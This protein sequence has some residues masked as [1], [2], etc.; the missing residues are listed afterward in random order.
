MFG[1]LLVYACVTTFSPGPNNILLL[2]MAG[3]QGVKKC[4]KLMAGI[5]TGFFFVMVCCGLFSAGL[6]K[7]VPE[8]MPYAKYVGAAYIFWLA[9]KTVTRQPMETGNEKQREPSFWMGLVLQLVNVKII[10][11][12]ISAF[13]GFILPY[14]QGTAVLLFYSFVLMAA[15]AAGNMIWAFIGNIC[16]K[17][18]SRY[19]K[20][21]NIVMA[22]LLLWCA[23]KMIMAS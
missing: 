19:Y 22:L 20:V 18:Y 9:W 12:G 10:L 21:F 1:S 3:Q 2:S 17:F 6:A 15:G 8:I 7:M 23:Y 4:F 14:A 13:T 5:W 11:Y 16:Q